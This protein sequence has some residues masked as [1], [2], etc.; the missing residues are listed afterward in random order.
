MSLTS[1]AVAGPLLAQLR[2]QGTEQAFALLAYCFMSDHVHLVV[3]GLSE[4]ADLRLFVAR[5]KQATDFWFRRAFRR[6]VWMPGYYDRILRD[7][8]S[9]MDA[10][11]YVMRNPIRAGLAGRIGEYQFAGSDVFSMQELLE[12]LE[13]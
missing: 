2:H 13:G 12:V 9:T 1:P 6:A 7:G 10:V 11:Q 8:D 3:E 5:W 4:A